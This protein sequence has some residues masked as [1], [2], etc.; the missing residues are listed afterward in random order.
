M[1]IGMEVELPGRATKLNGKRILCLD[2]VRFRRLVSSLVYNFL[3][4][5]IRLIGLVLDKLL[6]KIGFLEIEKMCPSFYCLGIVWESRQRLKKE[7]IVVIKLEP[8]CFNIS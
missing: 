4:C 5:S 1:W 3:M 2:K 8:A 7:V 6:S